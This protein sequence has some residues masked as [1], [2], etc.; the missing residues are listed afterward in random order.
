MNSNNSKDKWFLLSD[1]P[2]ATQPFGVK[3]TLY[4]HQLANLYDMEYRERL[5]PIQFTAYSGQIGSMRS[6]MALLGD[7]P[8]YGKTLS[9]LSLI[10]NN[11]VVRDQIPPE[12][13]PILYDID[14]LSVAINRSFPTKTSYT[15]STLIVVP[16]KLVNH[17]EAEIK[18]HTN[19]TYYIIDKNNMSPKLDVNNIILLR[20][21]MW[22]AFM[23]YCENINW[24]RVIFDEADNLPSLGMFYKNERK[25][26]VTF[27]YQARFEWY[28]TATY[29]KLFHRAKTGSNLIL[30]KFSHILAIDDVCL[31]PLL[32]VRCHEEFLKESF[33]IVPYKERHILCITPKIISCLSG[34]VNSSV[35]DK[36]NGGDI[37]GALSE[38]GC[39]PNTDIKS[40]LEMEYRKKINAMEEKIVETKRMKTL[41]VGEKD[42]RIAGYRE[43]INEYNNKIIS[44]D[45]YIREL[46]KDVC[47]IC[48]SEPESEV[49]VTCCHKI[50]CGACITRWITTDSSKRSC[51][52]CRDRLSA[53]K[54]VSCASNPNHQPRIEPKCPIEDYREILN[55][56]SNDSNSL[57]YRLP[58]DLHRL[59]DGYISHGSLRSKLNTMINIIKS[60]PHGRF[61]IFSSVDFANLIVELKINN[62]T[63][64][65]LKGVGYQ[66]YINE[67][68]KGIY[69]V[70]LL[71]ARYNGAGIDLSEATDVI[72]YH[73]Q[74]K[75][76]ETQ[77]IG[78][79]QRFGRNSQLTVH[80]LEYENEYI[81]LKPMK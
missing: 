24:I 60:K 50:F 71:N 37:A 66:K 44:S 75:T 69:N 13:L 29:D 58:R 41:A 9:I 45:E 21:D 16:P 76:I 73:R 42:R 26:N 51:P 34:E 1:S 59:L 67:F 54:I 3:T 23:R 35:M 74:E 53:E 6:K 12:Q 10:A 49:M 39:L 68:K 22:S 57:Y 5:N 8:G 56:L 61:L 52:N 17:W 2:K 19:L 81:N 48:M 43:T 65:E 30:C 18:K 33:S 80:F 79:A 47:Q 28:V 64:H 55:E 27:T 32:T 46:F 78:R 4:N 63:Y 20:S 77:N 25:E 31:L 72:M 7:P 14:G 15:S 36:L 38:I 70:I 40:V 62:I 11:A